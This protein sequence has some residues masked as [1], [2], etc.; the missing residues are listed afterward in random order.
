MTKTSKTDASGA[1][2]AKLNNR[3]IN[4]FQNLRKPDILTAKKEETD[5][6]IK[7]RQV[8]IADNR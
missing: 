5:E 3:L 8:Y 6:T 1:A 2:T 7:N 4:Q